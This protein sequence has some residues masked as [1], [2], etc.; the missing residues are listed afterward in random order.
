MKR[1]VK[2]F[3]NL[4]LLLCSIVMCC[5]FCGACKSCKDE[6]EE[7]VTDVKLNTTSLELLVDE[8]YQL[9]VQGAKESVLWTNNAEDVVSVTTDGQVKALSLGSACVTAQCGEKEM[10]CEIQVVKS[11]TG[12]GKLCID[13]PFLQDNNTGEMFVGRTYS[14]QARIYNGDTFVTVDPS[15]CRFVYN[16][17]FIEV[18]QTEGAVEITAKKTG[19]TTLSCVA[20]YDGKEFSS[21]SYSI[22]IT[23]KTILMLEKDISVLF[24]NQTPSGKENTMAT[25]RVFSIQQYNPITGESTDLNNSELTWSSSNEKIATVSSDGRITSGSC[26]DVLITATYAEK[27]LEI[28][29]RVYVPICSAEDLDVLSLVTYEQRNNVE[30]AKKVLSGYYIFA[31]DIDYSTH[32]R[33]YILPIASVGVQSVESKYATVAQHSGTTSYYSLAWKNMLS[34][35]EKQVEDGVYLV[36]NDGSEFCGVNP[37]RLAFTGV[38]DGNGYKIKNAWLMYDNILGY[39]YSGGWTGVYASFVGLNE[40]VIENICFDNVRMPDSATRMVD[41]KYSEGNNPSAPETISNI[42]LAQVGKIASSN[43]ELLVAFQECKPWNMTEEP[44]AMTII[45]SG[46]LR[47][48]KF[49]SVVTARGSRHNNNFLGNGLTLVNK[50]IITDNV[51]N[52]I[53]KHTYVSVL[54]TVNTFASFN[55][56]GGVIS[57]SYA[58]VTDLWIARNDEFNP[59]GVYNNEGLIHG[60]CKIY[61]SCQEVN[62][63]SA[64][65][66][67]KAWRYAGVNAL[68]ELIENMYQIVD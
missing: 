32:V 68:P 53:L 35:Q 14:M 40:G 51:V 23:D 49:T 2:N 36:S 42:Y 41:N 65:L 57:N 4:I 18:S 25:S 50:G 8:T 67:S 66:S 3:Y 58:L 24:T 28:P 45:N 7:V 62:E 17:E 12:T 46:V 38:I 13:S 19:D 64:A 22:S 47:N 33:N 10:Q 31:N 26:G 59:F 16:D 29:L 21:D 54:N 60:E 61:S 9:E 1:T 48:I 30:E 55:L 44:S 34:L 63:A 6:P 11:K 5:I 52:V 15:D 43:K 39:R 37:N 27:T 56:D 20:Q